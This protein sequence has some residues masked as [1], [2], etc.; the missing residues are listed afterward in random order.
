MTDQSSITAPRRLERPGGH[1]VAYHATPGKSPGVVFC[2]G[3]SSDMTGT[4]AIAL[5][6]FCR[7][8]GRAYVRFD[9]LGHGA[10][11]GKFEQGTIGRWADDAIAV[12][13]ATT[14]GP[15]VLVGS[16]MGGW[17]M[18]LA[19]LERPGRVCG[20]VGVAAAPD[21]TEDLV[22][23]R[24]DDAQRAALMRDGA[25]HLPSDYDDEPYAITRALIEDGRERLLLHAPIPITCPVRLIQGMND[26]DVPWETVLRIAE[27]LVSDDVEVTL[28][29]GGDHRLSE[30]D[31]LARLCRTVTEL[32]DAAAE[33]SA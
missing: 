8:E 11:S 24:F 12:I 23:N 5:D 33:K 13:D 26:A 30:P 27:R 21:F 7:G 10:S 4:K 17:I 29:K 6:A 9:Y 16:S 28:V 19:A 31:D 20:L 32:L 18:L 3:F 25:V 15:L 1:T 14:E 2:G 22:R